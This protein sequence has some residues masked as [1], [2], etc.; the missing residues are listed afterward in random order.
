[1]SDKRWLHSLQVNVDNDGNPQFASPPFSEALAISLL[2]PDDTAGGQT[3][4]ALK[5]A[6]LTTGLQEIILIPNDPDDDIRMG[7]GT[8]DAAS[9]KLPSQGIALPIGKTLADTLKFFCTAGAYVTLIEL[10]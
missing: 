8:I 7:T 4:A 5:G 3:L 6:A 10:G 1:M 2:A 9:A